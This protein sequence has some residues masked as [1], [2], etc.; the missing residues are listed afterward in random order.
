MHSAAR[1][2]G[3]GGRMKVDILLFSA[4][5]I[6]QRAVRLERDKVLVGAMRMSAL[7]TCKK[8]NRKIRKGA[9]CPRCATNATKGKQFPSEEK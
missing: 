7:T 1:D 6:L 9:L 3:E 4:A 2:G 8:C 5:S